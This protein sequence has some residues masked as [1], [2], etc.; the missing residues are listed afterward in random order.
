MTNERS[1]DELVDDWHN[2]V[3][4]SLEHPQQPLDLAANIKRDEAGGTR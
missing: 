2:D 3:A 1:I 4:G